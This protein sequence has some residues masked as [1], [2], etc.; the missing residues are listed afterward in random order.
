MFT[1]AGEVV[2]NMA[3]LGEDPIMY[4][5]DGDAPTVM[6]LLD[7]VQLFIPAPVLSNVN[8]SK[9]VESLRDDKAK[10]AS[11]LAEIFETSL[12]TMKNFETALIQTA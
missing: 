8:R 9:V 5:R 4:F 6:D 2:C 12:D 11:I 3:A 10:T 7:P 1:R